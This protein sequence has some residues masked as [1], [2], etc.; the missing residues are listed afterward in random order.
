[1]IDNDVILDEA[2][3]MLAS[4][5]LASRSLGRLLLK[6]IKMN[7]YVP[8]FWQAEALLHFPNPSLTPGIVLHVFTDVH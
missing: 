6:N 4:L 7:W 5:P 8:H 3:D 1:M 2:L